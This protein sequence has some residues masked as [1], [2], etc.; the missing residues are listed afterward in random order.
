LFFYLLSQIRVGESNQAMKKFIMNQEKGPQEENFKTFL[1]LSI[2]P[3]SGSK[4]PVS[5]IKK[6]SKA[7][8]T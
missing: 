1:D 6:S 4:C 8:Q 2:R 5:V 3:H 7:T